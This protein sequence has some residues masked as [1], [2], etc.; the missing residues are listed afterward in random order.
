MMIKIVLYILFIILNVFFAYNDAKRIKQDLPIYHGIIGSIYTI[1]L[2]LSYLITQNLY[3]TLGF[4]LIRIPVFNIS[5]NYFRGNDLTY[6][7]DST[8]SIVDKITNF[9]P[10]KIGYWRYSIL[11]C[12][13]S[14][15][16]ILI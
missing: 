14:L 6:L 13:L 3:A 7:S 5:L 15:I 2:F 4:M 16:L 1:L 10:K 9:I 12:I 8:T 11:I